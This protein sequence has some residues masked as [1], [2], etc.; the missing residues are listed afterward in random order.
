MSRKTRKL[1]W[2]VPLVAVF[3]VVRRAGCLH[4]RCVGPRRRVRRTNSPCDPQNLVVEPA[5][6]NAGRTTL[7]LT[8]DAPESG[9]AVRHGYRIDVSKDNKRFTFLCRD[10][11]ADTLTYTHSRISG[12]EPGTTQFYRVFAMNAPASA[13]RV[14]TWED[15][16]TK[17][18]TTPG[19][20]EA[21]P[22]GL[23]PIR[24]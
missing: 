5:D 12:S 14:S 21:V 20:G 10:R 7:V 13:G 3:A 11:C 1:I 8:W 24:N 23:P 15:G 17:K 9:A 22:I 19:T 2:S 4:D 16:T 6:G 18:I